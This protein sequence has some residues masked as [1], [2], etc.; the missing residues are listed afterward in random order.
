MKLA[1][2]ADREEDGTA[3]ALGMTILC[4]VTLALWIRQTYIEVF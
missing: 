2:S 4:L 1:L 3:N